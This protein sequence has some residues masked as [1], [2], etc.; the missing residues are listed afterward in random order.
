MARESL[1][2][3]PIE[4][5]CPGCGLHWRPCAPEL[6]HGFLC[7]C[8]ERLK[9]DCLPTLQAIEPGPMDDFAERKESRAADL[10]R[11]TARNAE[12]TQGYDAKS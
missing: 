11:I 12:K 2:D 4:I 5:Q 7:D 9:R 1:F 6:Q 3:I 10:A 8:G